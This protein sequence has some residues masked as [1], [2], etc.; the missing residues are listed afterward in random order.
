MVKGMG[1]PSSS[2][3]PK[4]NAHGFVHHGF[5]HTARALLGE[6]AVHRAFPKSRHAISFK[7]SARHWSLD[8]KI[9]GKNGPLLWAL[10]PFKTDSRAL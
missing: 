3:L 1:L 10:R 8:L 6:D 9:K 5:V 4:L 2:N 7:P